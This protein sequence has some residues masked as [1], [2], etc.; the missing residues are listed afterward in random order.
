MT[1]TDRV[2]LSKSKSTGKE[3]EKYSFKTLADIEF[4]YYSLQGPLA[5]KQ[6]PNTFYFCMILNTKFYNDLIGEGAGKKSVMGLCISY[7]QERLSLDKNP[8]LRLY[9]PEEHRRLAFYSI[10]KFSIEI[11][12]KNYH[13]A[14]NNEPE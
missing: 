4:F 14:G 2:R 7:L 5:D 11:N 13:F 9:N 12:D 10:D 1:H 6:D 8:L 3:I